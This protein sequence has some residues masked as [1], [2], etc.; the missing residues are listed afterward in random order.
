MDDMSS[1]H[2]F[3][4]CGFVS[5][6]FEADDLDAAVAHVMATFRSHSNPDFDGDDGG[7]VGQDDEW[8]ECLQ[9]FVGDTN[10][11]P[12]NADRLAEAI[13]ALTGPDAPAPGAP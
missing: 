11:N 6:R 10:H 13:A 8:W 5:P 3:E 9:T 2:Y 7:I 1:Y 4:A 12:G